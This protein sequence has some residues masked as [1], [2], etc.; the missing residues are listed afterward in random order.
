MPWLQL[1]AIVGS[2][3][4]EKRKVREM[5]GQLGESAKKA[6]TSWGLAWLQRTPHSALG[7]WGRSPVN[8]SLPIKGSG[9]ENVTQSFGDWT[10][11][12]LKRFLSSWGTRG[13]K[14][15]SSRQQNFPG[16]SVWCCIDIQTC[17]RGVTG[18]RRLAAKFQEA[19]ECSQ[20][21]WRVWVL[22][23]P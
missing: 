4:R 3:G 22:R 23:G 11:M 13:Q 12:Q 1:T 9:C 16:L 17:K 10:G 14:Y 8:K 18:P 20:R 21:V 5:G 2:A 19:S 6:I 15:I 7:R